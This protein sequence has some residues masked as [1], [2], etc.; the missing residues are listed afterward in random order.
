[1]DA[2]APFKDTALEALRPRLAALEPR[3]RA[4]VVGIRPEARRTPPPTGGW[5]VDDCL[6]HLCRT[7]DLYLGRRLPAVIATARHRPAPHRPFAPSVAG[8]LML[9]AL[10]EGNRIRLPAPGRL[11]VRERDTVRE[12]VLDA[13]VASVERLASQMREADG[14]DLRV[15]FRSP[16]SPL[17]H[18]RL[19]EAFAILIEHAHRHLAQ[20][21]RARAAIGA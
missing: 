17:V 8:R 2:I 10:R 16:I 19:G 4:L 15:S 12:Q 11:R 5:S 20:A 14:L 9:A 7:H 3:A 1:M 13:F 21:E 18:L 6:E